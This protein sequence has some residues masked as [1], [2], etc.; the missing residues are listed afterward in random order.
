MDSIECPFCFGYV[1]E[2]VSF[3][4]DMELN[5]KVAHIEC[6]IKNKCP[7]CN[8]IRYPSWVDLYFCYTCMNTLCKNCRDEKNNYRCKECSFN[9]DKIKYKLNNT[10]PKELIEKIFKY[11]SI[12]IPSQVEIIEKDRNIM[13][14]ELFSIENNV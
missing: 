1:Y 13:K 12:S 4:G 8:K 3:S 6:I 14:L 7:K 11:S 9:I 2:G 5:Q 10:L